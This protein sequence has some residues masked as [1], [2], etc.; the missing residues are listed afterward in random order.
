MRIGR[1][2]GA[3]ILYGGWLLLHNPDARLDA[4]LSVWKKLHEYDTSY[5]C[6]QGRGKS[7]ADLLHDQREKRDG[8]QLT[9]VQAQLRYRCERVE[10]FEA[11]QPH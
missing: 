10:R 5:L 7:V 2:A 3:V 4:P 9:P 6:E 11:L 8:P 1:Q